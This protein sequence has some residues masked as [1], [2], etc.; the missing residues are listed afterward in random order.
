MDSQEQQEMMGEEI[1]VFP[2]EENMLVKSARYCFIL[3]K[4]I[5]KVP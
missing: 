3:V 5:S 2:H 4:V 1:I